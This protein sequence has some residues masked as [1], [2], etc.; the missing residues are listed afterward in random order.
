MSDRP[1]PS[2]SLRDAASSSDADVV[3][4]LVGH[5]EWA[6]KAL[7][8]SNGK[9]VYGHALRIVRDPH[10]AE[11]IAQDALLALW[12]QP[13]R[14]D[15]SKGSL[16]SFLIAAARFKAIDVV[17]RQERIRSKE[18]LLV[19][20]AGFFET[21]PADRGVAEGMELRT[22]LSELCHIQRQALFLAYYEGLTYGQVAEVLGLPAGTIK[23]RIRDGLINLRTLL[24][25]P[26]TG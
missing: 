11:E 20:S 6:L 8:D 9:Y 22:A 3:A 17:R 12:W 18:S 13:E 7:I 24:R 25:V 23:T 14:F 1:V 16:R 10:L 2:G 26:T 15:A 4:G 21:A 5:E 19:E